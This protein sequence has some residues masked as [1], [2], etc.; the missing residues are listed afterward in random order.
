MSRDN[1]EAYDS[2]R[3]TGPLH[4]DH[5]EDLRYNR[6]QAS[7]QRRSRS[8]ANMYQ[9]GRDGRDEYRPQRDSG[10]YQND[11]SYRDQDRREFTF[12]SDNQ[13]Q[14]PPTE[15][16]FERKRRGRGG[17]PDSSRR[18]WQE[19]KPWAPKAAVNRDIL[20]SKVDRQTTPERLNGM[21]EAPTRFK[22]LDE[23][24]ESSSE[25]DLGSDGEDDMEEGKDDDGHSTK[26]TKQ[27][28]ATDDGNSVPKWSNPDPYTALPPSDVSRGKKTDVVDFIRK[29]KLAA[30][31]EK[32]SNQRNDVADNVDFISFGMDDEETI[33]PSATAESTQP[34]TSQAITGSMNDLPQ[35]LSVPTP[36][37][38]NQFS[39]LSNLHPMLNAGSST[40]TYPTPVS[41]TQRYSAAQPVAD[42][43]PPRDIDAAVGMRPLQRQPKGKKR[44]HIVD[45]EIE[46]EWESVD[47]ASATPWC[48]VDHSD[49][50]NMGYW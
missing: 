11:R 31:Q 19:R 39:H 33:V 7:A 13:T 38:S 48:T 10:A 16:R 4:S 9:F 41:S 20:H 14:F 3:P 34:V 6:P 8:P 44:K 49:T 15:P 50:E 42:S 43:W 18:E 17:R 30:E 23:L 35:K 21:S 25:M 45:G 40:T 27:D 24:S 26:R 32:E 2:Y 36:S 5:E 47:R 29:A 1:R 37:T 22:N 46:S 12:R 28:P